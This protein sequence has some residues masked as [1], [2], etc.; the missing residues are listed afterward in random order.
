MKE[1][2]T[3]VAFVAL[4]RPQFKSHLYCS[5]S[6]LRALRDR[7]IVHNGTWLVCLG[8]GRCVVPVEACTELS[9]PRVA[10]VCPAFVSV[11]VCL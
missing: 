4:L 2:E 10:A 3:Y 1:P 5:M 7:A 6:G 8:I 11:C 9:A